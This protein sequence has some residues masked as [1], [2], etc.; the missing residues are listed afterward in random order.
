MGNALMRDAL[1]HAKAA[2]VHRGPAPPADVRQIER[3]GRV[4]ARLPEPGVREQR[5]D[6]GPPPEQCEIEE[7]WIAR[8]QQCTDPMNRGRKQQREEILSDE[9]D[10]HR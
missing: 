6:S 9:E 3:Q 4:A 10:L 8:T 1:L 2:E 7:T 5:R